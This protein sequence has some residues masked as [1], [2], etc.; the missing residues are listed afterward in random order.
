MSGLHFCSGM[1]H[2]MDIGC[3]FWSDKMK[4]DEDKKKLKHNREFF[5][6]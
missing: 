5:Q 2:W 4:D 3:N 6:K 1:T